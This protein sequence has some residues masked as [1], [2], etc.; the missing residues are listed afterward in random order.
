MVVIGVVIGG[1]G[2][3]ARGGVAVV[4]AASRG[5]PRPCSIVQR[6]RLG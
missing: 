3:D 4:R 2:G 5:W 6:R 1:V